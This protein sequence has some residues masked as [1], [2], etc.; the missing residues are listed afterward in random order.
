MPE[1]NDDELRSIALAEA[2]R[3]MSGMAVDTDGNRTTRADE[4][5]SAAN[6]FFNFLKGEK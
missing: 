1:L 4:V 6:A 2:V 5:V 3:A